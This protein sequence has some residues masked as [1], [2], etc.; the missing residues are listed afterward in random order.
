MDQAIYF[1]ISRF[2]CVTINYA[3]Y[4]WPNCWSMVRL[5]EYTPTTKRLLFSFFE[6]SLKPFPFH[7]RFDSI[8]FC[9]FFS[10]ENYDVTRQSARS[11]SAYKYRIFF[12]DDAKNFI[13]RQLCCVCACKAIII[14]ACCAFTD[15]SRCVFSYAVKMQ[16]LFDE[17]FAFLVD[18][19][20]VF[21]C[22]FKSCFGHKYFTTVKH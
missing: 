14:F 1:G 9:L 16:H 17:I 20:C 8:L 13:V 5:R 18:L 19:F 11:R 4:G 10:L 15:V 7:S 2:W 6:K 12:F 22:R 3:C 21:V